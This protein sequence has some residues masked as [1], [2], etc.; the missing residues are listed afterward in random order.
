[1]TARRPPST[2]AEGEAALDALPNVGAGNVAVTKISDTSTHQEWRI[3]FQGSL[4]GTDVAQ[5]TIDA[6]SISTYSGTP[7]EIETTDVDGG[8]ANELQR[9]GFSDSYQL[10]SG[11]FTLTF[12]SQ[13]TA[14][15]K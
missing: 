11:S 7:A 2:A 4:E 12:E 3:T 14:A 1:M 6:S 10:F 5:V 8:A 13:T 15:K 9:V